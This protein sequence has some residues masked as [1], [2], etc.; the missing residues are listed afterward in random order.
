MLDFVQQKTGAVQALAQQ[1]LNETAVLAQQRYPGASALLTKQAAQLK[2]QVALLTSLVATQ[3]RSAT[4]LPLSLKERAEQSMP[5]LRQRCSASLVVAKCWA[6]QRIERLRSSSP[7]KSAKAWAELAASRPEVSRVQ[8]Q[9]SEV[10]SAAVARY[11]AAKLLAA[12]TAEQ[13][14]GFARAQ[15]EMLP[16]YRQRVGQAAR[17]AEAWVRQRVASFRSHQD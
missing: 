1:H 5:E 15:K 8:A 17:G 16:S 9:A 2:A 14:V 7:V 3:C 6:S 12:A 10:R 13:L 4:A 11:A